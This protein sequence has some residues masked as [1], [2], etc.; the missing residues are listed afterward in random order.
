MTINIEKP[1]PHGHVD[2][3]R[4]IKFEKALGYTLPVNYRNYLLEFNGGVPDQ[5]FFWIEEGKDGTSIYQFYGLHSSKSSSLDMFIGDDHCGVPSGFLPI[6]DDG[7]GNNII[8]CLVGSYS[9]FIYFL[10]HEIHPY[11]Q[12]ESMDG[13]VK[14]ADSFSSIIDILLPEPV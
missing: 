12:H 14:I 4:L 2:E 13:I 5:N 11:N 10:D 9:G 6:G 7:V 3:G 1:N 8:I